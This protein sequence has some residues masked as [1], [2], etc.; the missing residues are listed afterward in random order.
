MN[1]TY[2][3]ITGAALLIFLSIYFFT[4]EKMAAAPRGCRHIKNINEC[5]PGY[6]LDYKSSFMGSQLPMGKVSQNTQVCCV[7]EESANNALKDLEHIT[8][9]DNL[10]IVSGLVGIKVNNFGRIKRFQ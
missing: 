8:L 9:L 1:Y 2:L 5:S 3:A 4:A 10:H 7:D 6:L